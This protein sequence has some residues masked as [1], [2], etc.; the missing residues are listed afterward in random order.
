MTI[1]SKKSIDYI[2]KFTGEYSTRPLAALLLINKE[3]KLS[4]VVYTV[5]VTTTRVTLTSGAVSFSVTYSNK[6]IAQVA[7]ELSNSPFPIEVRPL[8]NIQKLS[9]GEM[10]STISPLQ[11]PD[12]FDTINRSL[13]GGSAILRC[14]RYGLNY[15][16]SA[17][18]NLKAP[19]FGNSTLPWF[20]RIS[21]GTFSQR[22]KSNIYHFGIPEYNDQVWSSSAGKPYIDVEGEQANFI[23][24][25]AIKLAKAPVFYKNNII[26]TNSSGERIYSSSLIKDVDTIN[27]IVY[28]DQ[29]VSLPKDLL[30]YY[31]YYEKNL[32]YKGINLNGHFSQNPYILNKYIVFYALPIKSSVGGHRSRGIYHSV[33]SSI[34][35]AIY[36]ITVENTNEPLTIIGAINV[37]SSTSYDDISIVDTRSY[38]GGLTTDE[39]GKATEKK[40]KES[41]YFFDIGRVEGIPYP[42]TAAIV[43]DIP[44]ELK[45]VLTISE[46]RDRASKFIAA[47]VYP[48]MS[49]TNETYYDQFK[50]NEYN[51]D[52][53]FVNYSLDE[54]NQYGSI[55][56]YGLSGK[57]GGILNINYSVP[58]GI[59]SLYY[60][61]TGQNICPAK[62]GDVFIIPAGEKYKVSFIK[63]SADAMFSY[64]WK[65]KDS[66]WQ[67]KT[68]KNTKYILTGN[69]SCQSFEIDGSY[70]Y[71]EI[72]NL[73]GF[74]PYVPSSLFKQDLLL[75]T[76]KIIEYTKHISNNYANTGYIPNIINPD[77]ESASISIG[78]PKLLEPLYVNYN[79]MQENGYYSF[80]DCPLISG[81][82]AVVYSGTIGN[83]FPLPFNYLTETYESAY[84]GTYNA[85]KDVYVYSKYVNGRVNETVSSFGSNTQVVNF[86]GSAGWISTNP[87]NDATYAFSGANAILNK[88]FALSPFSNSLAVNADIITPFYNP[89]T[90]TAI[91]LSSTY[92]NSEVTSGNTLVF[93]CD[94]IKAVAAFYAAQTSPSTGVY[95]SNV[96]TNIRYNCR[97]LAISGM[98]TWN[99]YFN[100][101]FNAPTYSG[102]YLK[103]TNIT[104]YN[105]ISLFASNY[106]DSVCSAYDSIYYGNKAWAGWTGLES[107]SSIYYNAT[108]NP[109]ASLSGDTTWSSSLIWPSLQSY[110]AKEALSIIPS[111]IQS[112]I[113]TISNYINAISYHGGIIQP[114]IFK[115]LK[116]LLW[117]PTHKANGNP[118]IT[119]NYSSNV[120]TFE[121]GMGAALKGSL[122]EDGIIIEG[123]SFN[124]K[125]APFEAT[126][127]NDMLN[128]ALYA[129]KYYDL[130]QDSKSKNRWLSIAEGIYRTTENLYALSGGYP[131]TVNFTTSV[132]GDP[133]SA[134][135]NGYLQILNVLDEP[136]TEDQFN[137][138]TGQIT[139]IF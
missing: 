89:S 124:Y 47:G 125:P 29:S 117:H 3:Y 4:N 118:F 38:G 86:T 59:Y 67:T 115:A 54:A 106:L 123:G 136:I 128:A 134:V 116:Y 7:Q 68:V 113:S 119:G 51:A 1:F 100:L 98:A 79:L 52:I 88:V 5:S 19:Y 77:L 110:T 105:R 24:Q 84:N 9:T 69:L 6:S 92:G 15:D 133:G 109:V 36:S 40:F 10:V 20:A 103:N 26:F 22:Y 120:A 101:Y 28:L 104:T 139:R 76:T 2:R 53:S 56:T 114:G 137:Y 37:Q 121:I 18:F 111:E 135:L 130:I 41:Q 93:G 96:S 25:Y 13:N 74:S 39:L 11:I 91:N 70:G 55:S 90:N 45:E 23:S 131:Y 85:L 112:N 35:D 62:T 30:V 122:N 16:N 82:A 60:S 99:A 97:D 34:T 32:I 83:T 14:K 58:S 94:Y 65:T 129:V 46:I 12:G 43:L 49:I 27:G 33:G 127:P 138:Y 72:R 61:N 132:S 44:S 108:Y 95:N 71:K 17:V 64:E 21:S 78:V 8:A 66:E 81:H 80:S 31:T 102:T 57:V 63:G 50:T 107:K 126:V 75:S 48:V 42:G 73:T 87:S